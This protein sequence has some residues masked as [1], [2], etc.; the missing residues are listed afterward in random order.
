[1]RKFGP[2]GIGEWRLVEME[3]WDQEFIDLDGP[4]FIAFSNNGQG[5]MKFGAVSLTLDWEANHERRVEFS[6]EGFDEMDEVSGF[7]W[8]ELREDLLIGEI[9][10]HQGERSGFKAS[11][12]T[13]KARK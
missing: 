10:F 7:G 12:S 9:R 4:G 11:R 5:E 1:M 2:N 13:P 8:A 3:Q 6:F